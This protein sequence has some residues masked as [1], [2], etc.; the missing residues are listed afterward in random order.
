MNK[1][2]M[3]KILQFPRIE[4]K[5]LTLDQIMKELDMV[6][7]KTKELFEAS[8]QTKAEAERL[9]HTAK[10][11]SAFSITGWAILIILMVL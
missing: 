5:E 2:K 1:Q 4:T 8:E 7:V 11:I 10:A 3:G 6:V 9:L